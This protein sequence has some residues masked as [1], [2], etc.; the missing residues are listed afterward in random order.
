MTFP[1]AGADAASEAATV[2]AASKSMRWTIPAL[3]TTRPRG[4]R[5]PPV[6]RFLSK[7]REAIFKRSRMA[8]K[9]I[10]LPRSIA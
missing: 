1:E 6:P 7:I 4:M 9:R 3:N 2:A 5:F 10:R 8:P